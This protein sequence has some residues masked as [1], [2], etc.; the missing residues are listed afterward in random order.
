MEL[1]SMIRIQIM[2]NAECQCKVCHYV[3]DLGKDTSGNPL[4]SSCLL[5]YKDV[6]VVLG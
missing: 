5:K 6:Y 4:T 2:F 3:A 1:I